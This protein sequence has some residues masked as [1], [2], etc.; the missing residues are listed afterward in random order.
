MIG[1]FQ[2]VMFTM[3]KIAN[4]LHLD[5]PLGIIVIYL[6]FGAGLSVF[7]FSGF[8]KTIPLAGAVKG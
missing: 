3:A 1:P 8:I 5:N 6:G 7:T 4:V 2:M